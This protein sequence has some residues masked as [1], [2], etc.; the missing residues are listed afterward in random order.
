MAE[1][2]W[3]KTIKKEIS[4]SGIGLHSGQKVKINFLPAEAKTGIVFRRLDLPGQ[5]EIEVYPENVVATDR[6]TTLGRKFKGG[7]I[8]V[9]T[10]EHLMASIWYMGIDNLVIEIKGDEIPIMDGSARP[11]IETLKKVGVMNLNI[12]KNIFQPQKTIKVKETEKNFLVLLPYDGYKISFILDYDNQ[13]IGTQFYDYE[14]GSGSFFSE[15]AQART[16]GFKK[17]IEKLHE[18]GLA[19]GGSLENVLLLDE[20]SPVNEPRF[21]NEPVKH[22]VLDLIGD[23]ALNGFIQGHIIAIRSG[24]SLNVQ[25]A[26]KIK[27]QF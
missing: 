9:K 25:L 17:N 20:Q 8:V 3:E 5:P 27:E 22:K 23:M 4:F 6:C 19:L 7:K 12:S 11:F 14:A 26:K 24:H 15:V 13:V 16:F 10:V 1:E 21:T 18:Q 2:V